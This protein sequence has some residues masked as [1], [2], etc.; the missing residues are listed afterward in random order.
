MTG[1]CKVEFEALARLVKEL[2]ECAGA[3]RTAMKQLK[4][5]GPTGTGSSELEAACDEFQDK[6]GYGIKQIAKATGGITEKVA[7][8]GQVYQGLE[9][10]ITALLKSV[11]VGER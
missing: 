8:S 6:W 4:D 9:D 2:S 5:I 1:Y 11:K 3:M 10:E 7:K